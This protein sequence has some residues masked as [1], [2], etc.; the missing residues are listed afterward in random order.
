MG[1]CRTSLT[2]SRARVL[3]AF[4]AVAILCLAGRT[5]AFCPTG[6]NCDDE[7]LQVSCDEV[8]LEVI[9]ITFNPSVQVRARFLDNE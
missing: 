1:S 9:P 2:P 3:A 4:C 6:C 7:T 5:R 8:N